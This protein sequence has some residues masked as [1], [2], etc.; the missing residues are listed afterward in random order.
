MRFIHFGF[1]ILFFI[2][3]GTEKSAKE[4][5]RLEQKKDSVFITKESSTVIPTLK[6]EP[7]KHHMCIFFCLPSGSE[8]KL[9]R[10]R[11]KMS[12]MDLSVSKV[13]HYEENG[14]GELYF[15][16]ETRSEL[17]S[18][19]IEKIKIAAE[20]NFGDREYKG[21]KAVFYAEDLNFPDGKASLQKTIEHPV[22]HRHYGSG[23]DYQEKINPDFKDTT[24]S[25]F[26]TDNS[27]NLFFFLAKV[28]GG[29]S[30]SVADEDNSFFEFLR[31]RNKTNS[32][33]FKKQIAVQDDIGNPAP[34]I[35]YNLK[36]V[37]SYIFV[38]GKMKRE[39]ITEWNKNVD[40]DAARWYPP[41]FY[42]DTVGIA[43]E[44]FDSEK[45]E[46]LLNYIGFPGVSALE[47]KSFEVFKGKKNLRQRSISLKDNSGKKHRGFYI[48]FNNDKIPDL[49]WYVEKFKTMGVFECIAR[50]YVNVNGKWE[51]RNYD[52][53]S[54]W[55]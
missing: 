36:N 53:V 40:G 7:D 3:C 44:Y 38:D 51:L 24:P 52:S 10:I 25:F 4:E 13:K 32:V 48:D 29:G 1:I 42:V 46:S 39:K 18:L 31:E 33:I 15:Y 6:T 14:E 26:T 49:F 45:H 23:Q 16:A 37:Y 34:F 2:S 41:G 11:K 21:Y 55:G 19:Q 43:Q 22:I 12:A 28:N 47:E 27:G 30:L 20:N 35:I 8:K 17:D 5:T 50:I 9:E 54:F